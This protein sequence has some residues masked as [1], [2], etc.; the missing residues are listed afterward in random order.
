MG[1]GE[2]GIYYLQKGST[3]KRRLTLM[4][5]LSLMADLEIYGVESITHT[6]T[7]RSCSRK[8]SWRGGT[9][10]DDGVMMRDPQSG[11]EVEYITAFCMCHETH[12]NG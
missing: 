9:D 4:D 3:L 6:L 8:T 1:M 12:K 5:N 7:H 2:V 11:A 10:T